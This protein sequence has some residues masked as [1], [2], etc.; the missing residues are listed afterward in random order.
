MKRKRLLLL[1]SFVVV[2]IIGSISYLY[3]LKRDPNDGRSLN[4][5]NRRISKG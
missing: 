1:I 2:I 4:T 5:W 3:S